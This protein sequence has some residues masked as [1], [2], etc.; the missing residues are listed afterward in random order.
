MLAASARRAG[1][2]PLVVDSFADADLAAH[3]HASRHLPEAIHAGFH[4]PSLSRALDEMAAVAP[5]PPVG[6]VL[7][8]G[9]EESPQLVARLARRYQLLGCGA[10]AVRASK[11]P[12]RLFPLLA[13]MGI[14]HPETRLERPSEPDGWVSKRIGGSGGAHIRTL[15]G[16]TSAKGEG[17]PHRYYQRR[18]AGTPLS[19]M[20]VMSAKGEAVAFTRQWASPAPRQPYRYG[21]AAG[22][23]TLPS[24]LEAELISIVLPLGRRLG[25]VGLVSFDF[26]AGADGPLL[27]D[28]NPRPGATLDV[29]DDEAGTLLSAHV[30][31]CQGGDAAGLLARSWRPRHR[32]A[33][34][35]YA[36]QGPLVVSDVDWP[37]WTADRPPSGS[38]IA[39]LRPVTT[40]LA[41]AENPDLAAVQCRKRLETLAEIL[42]GRSSPCSPAEH[43]G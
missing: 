22:H 8:A 10:E 5:S 26:L 32:A 25:L 28:V 27:V 38:A 2:M 18:V 20:A 30:L 21:G 4:R 15:S 36:D 43:R 19:V 17:H 9:F 29:L 24:D 42:Y 13:E 35:L 7:G 6:L 11:D 34:Y 41:E 33:A 12:A 3:A 1:F 14:R 39:P 31:A 40:A 23:L 37:G 16:T